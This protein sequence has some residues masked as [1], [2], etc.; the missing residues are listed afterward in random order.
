MDSPRVRDYTG[1]DRKL[2]VSVETSPV[3]ELLLSMFVWGNKN[4]PE[5]YE[6]GS[7]FFEQ[8]ETDTPDSAATELDAM[9]DC[10]EIWLSLIGLAQANGVA[11]SVPEFLTHIGNMD[12]VA[13]RRVLINGA[14]TRTGM[15]DEEA[16]AAASGDQAAVA[17]VLADE[18]AGKGFGDLLESGPDETQR[19]LIDIISAVHTVLESSISESLP[20]LRRDADEK[21]SLSHSMEAPK[22]VEAATNGVTFKMQPQVTGVLLIPSKIIR[23]WTVIIEHEGMQIFAY[24]VSDENLN[25]DPDAPPTYLVDLYKALGDERRL[26]ILAMLKE[27]DLGLMDIAERVGLAKSTAHHHLRILRSAGLVRVTVGDSKS[28][29]LRQDRVPEAARLLDAYLTRSV[30]AQSASTAKS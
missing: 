27:S 14:C 9:V 15:N 24:S 13:L 29:S 23:P 20:P 3:Y 4:Q 16:E 30:G 28:Y 26:R 5:E 6:C 2:K 11:R 21:R 17:S 25:A 12:P 8:L 19:R 22:L 18:Y 10:G 1:T 7:T